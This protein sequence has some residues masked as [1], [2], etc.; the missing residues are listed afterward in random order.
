M[1]S[2]IFAKKNID[3]CLADFSVD[4]KGLTK[5]AAQKKLQKYGLNELR[6]KEATIWKILIRQFRSPFTYLLL[7]SGIITFSIGEKIDGMFIFSFILINT[8]L[9][10]FQEFRAEKIIGFLKQYFPHQIKVLRDNKEIV[11]EKKLLVPGDIVLLEAGNIVPADIRIIE[12]N[13]LMIDESVLSGESVPVTKTNEPMEKNHLINITEAHNMVFAGT[14]VLRG[15]LTGLIVSTGSGT[16]IG[17]IAQLASKA[18]RESI[19]EKEVLYFSKLIMKIVVTTILLLYITNL[20]IKGANNL[21]EFSFFSIALI[22]SILPEALPAVVTFAL[23]KGAMRMSKEKVVVRRMTAIED[24]GNIEILCTDKTGTITEGKL[25]LEEIIS[26]DE[27]RCILYSLLTSEDTNKSKL[28][29]NPFDSAIINHADPETKK[30][31]KNFSLIGRIPFDSFSMIETA[32]VKNAQG[33]NIIIAKGAPEIILKK[34]KKIENSQT[35]E[36]ILKEIKGKGKNGQRAVGIAYK[37]ISEKEKLDNKEDD[38]IFLG[39]LVFSDPLKT[40]A[41]E[42]ISLAKK[43]EI[44]FKIITGDS[45]EV[46]HY[47]A[48]KTGIIKKGDGVISADNLSQLNNSLFDKACE[49]YDVFARI[50]PDLKLRIIKSLQKKYEVGFLGEGINDAPALKAANVGIV[51]SNASD[52]SREVSDIVL[53]EKNLKVIVNGIRIGRNIFTNIN[54]YIKCALA[55]NFGNFYSIAVISLFIKFLPMLPVQIILGNILSDFPLIS[56]ATDKIEHEEAKKPRTNRFQN[57]LPLI[58]SLALVSTVFDFIFFA[59][60]YHAQPSTIQT[61]WFIESILTE[62][63]LIFIIRTKKFFLKASRPSFQLLSLV[64]LDFIFIIY[65]PFS[66]FGQKV[67]HFIKPEISNLLIVLVLLLGYFICS[68]AVKL[69][70]FRI[71]NNPA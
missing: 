65:L 22:V 28:V 19:Y 10:F 71:K 67:F 14:S 68:E 12:T 58:I 46:A 26:P 48:E 56:V 55:S 21:F 53:M 44:R 3:Q 24:L 23:A 64:V 36:E 54:K 32:H 16:A 1:N 57:F 69:I 25:K 62:L 43:L 49:D 30:M 45:P 34:S 61:L 41:K 50:S 52:V 42:S 39:Y 17:D 15:T 9:G 66:Q 6:P 31:L 40:T 2:L 47:I 33:Q 7:I 63:L 35:K 8:A 51:V 13:N 4:Q 27:S 5:E 11:I 38:F 37:N 59:I 29:L 70:Y 60:F 20:L 18:K